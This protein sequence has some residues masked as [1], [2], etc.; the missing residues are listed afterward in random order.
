MIEI[1]QKALNDKLPCK[2]IKD[3]G[4]TEIPPNSKTVVGIGPYYKSKI[5]KI[6]KNLKL[7]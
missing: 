3:K 2:L 7:L 6:T 4:L 5:D 1:Y